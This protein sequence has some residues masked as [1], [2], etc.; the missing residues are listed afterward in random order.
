MRLEAARV[1]ALKGHHVTLYEKSDRLG[2]TLVAAAEP[3][4][5]NRIRWFTQWQI[6]Q[7]K[8][9]KVNVVFN[10]TIT[11]DSE[12]LKEADNIIIAIGGEPLKLRI[13]GLD[14]DN[15]LPVVDY[16]LNP[17]KLKGQKILVMGGGASGCDCA[18]ELAME[19]KDVTLVEMQDAVAKKMVSYTRDPLL[20]ALKENHV[21]IL[22][23]T[24]VMEVNEKGASVDQ[25]GEKEFLDA[26]MIIDAFG[27]KPKRKDADAIFNKYG[28]MCAIIGDC[29]HT[30][31]IGEAV[32]GGYFAANAIH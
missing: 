16:H 21:N 13:P 7:L 3:S 23:N 11:A 22:C 20:Y 1:A 4:F 12:E 6:R 15:V 18:L 25:N 28:N 5:K 32:R 17:E 29:E 10:K 8:E 9:L 30:A 24:R 2:G 14:G 26:D 31:Q 19:G 27:V